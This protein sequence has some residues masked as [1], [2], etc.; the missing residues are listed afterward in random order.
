MDV[1]PQIP[2]VSERPGAVTYGPLTETPVDPDVVFLRLN[3]QQLMVLSDAIP[4]LRI[5]GKPQC[6]IVAVAKEQGEPAASVG[7]AASRTRTGMAATEMT[8]ALPASRLADIVA[9]VER[10]AIADAAVARYAADDARR[11]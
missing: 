5:E 8:C 11:F 6:H 3:G 2:V 7:C 1:V 4:G 9:A 10:N